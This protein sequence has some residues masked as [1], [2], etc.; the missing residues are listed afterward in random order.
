MKNKDFEI[1]ILRQH[2]IKDN[3]EDDK[4]DLCSHGKIYI[5]IGSEELCNKDSGS[6]TLSATGLYL[7]RSL[8]QDCGLDQF[9]NQL[10]PC[11]GNFMIP[12][13]DGE[14]Y[15]VITGCPNGIDWKIKHSNGNVIFESVKGSKGQ[16]IFDDY[17]NLVIDF[18]DKV[19][20]F[21]GSPDNK[22]L[23]DEE[24]DK[25]G[26]KHFWAEWKELKEKWK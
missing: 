11:C 7:L 12:D 9:S 17:K 1:K 13:E 15:V 10:V 23:P 24:F 18:T 25:N 4:E 6:W 19:E 5:R 2:W 20:K 26:F 14:N 3:G 8:E 22:I 16:M 21:Y